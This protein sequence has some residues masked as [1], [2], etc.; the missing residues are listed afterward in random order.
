MSRIYPVPA[1]P[2]LSKTAGCCRFNILCTCR[3]EWC[4]L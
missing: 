1:Q 3:R 4:F 2:M